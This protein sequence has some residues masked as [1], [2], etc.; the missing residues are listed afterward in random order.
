MYGKVRR[1]D[2]KFIPFLYQGQYYDEETELAYNRFRYY[3]PDTGSYISQDPIGLA[4]G[5]PNMYAYT[6]DSNSWIDPLGLIGAPSTV[7]NSPGIYSLS[8][9]T[10]NQA[11][12][13]SA[14]D[15]NGRMSNT[16]H[17]KA[18]DLLGHPDTK[19]EFTPVDLG[20]ADKWKDQNRILRHYEQKEKMRMENAGFD[21]TNSNNPEATSKN[22]RNK[23]IAKDKGASAGK[24]IKCN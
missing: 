18:Q 12:A 4:G 8:N 6:H 14:L 5:M 7:P 23:G 21:M 22:A 16:S 17:T 15:A 19:V 13:G 1:G 2:N 11:Y 9:T 3:S 24:R 10:T 20:D